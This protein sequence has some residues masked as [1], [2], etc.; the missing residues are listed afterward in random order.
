MKT[1]AFNAAL[2]LSLLLAA[3]CSSSTDSA[4][5][6]DAA[7]DKK[8]E[9][10]D[11]AGAKPATATTEGDAKDVADYLVALANTGRAE[12]EMSQVAA[13]RATSPAVKSYASKTVAQHAQDEQE[14]K[15]E[16]SKYNVTLPT[17]LA[18]DSQ[19]MLTDL[20][21]EKNGADFD[22]KY[23]DD[24]A[25]VNDKAISKAKG[26]VSNTSKPEL[27]TFVQKIMGDDQ[28]HMDE[29]KSLKSAMK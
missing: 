14:L 7:N 8:I 23:L 1:T 29:A 26:L 27:Q 21:T 19:K 11:S 5:V 4:K 28:K 2:L 25:D 20:G 10:A 18:D 9:S 3:G 6:A 24:M 13:T 17:A 22:K 15:A 12:Y 16:A